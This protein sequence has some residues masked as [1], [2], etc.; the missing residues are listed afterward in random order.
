MRAFSNKHLFYASYAAFS[1]LGGYRGAK[2]YNHTYEKRVKNAIQKTPPHVPPQYYY[3]ECVLYGTLGFVYYAVPIINIVMLVKE[4]Y[5]LEVNIRGLE[6]DK[7]SDDYY[8]L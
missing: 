3:I 8:D 7:N 1:G 6:K 2:S 5:R 4:L